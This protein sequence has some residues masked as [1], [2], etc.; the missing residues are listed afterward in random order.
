MKQVQHP[1]LL[2]LVIGI[3]LCADC[4]RHSQP[5]QNNSPA[6]N[7]TPVAAADQNTNQ[8]E[9]DE[10][11]RREALVEAMA[12]AETGYVE[13]LNR[14]EVPL[15]NYPVEDFNPP[16]DY[17][18][19]YSTD[20][21]YPGYLLCEYPVD[22]AQYFQTN[23]PGWFK[24]ALEQIRKLGPQKFPPI[25]WVAVAI[26]NRAEQKGAST[27]E[28]SYKVGAIFKASDVFNRSCSLSQMIAHAAM[29]RHPFEY[30][31]SQPTPGDRQ[32]WLIVEQHAATNDTTSGQPK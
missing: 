31:T 16:P 28:Q 25:K 15:P 21:H 3:F 32:R 23:E 29:D 27:F 22:E 10:Q 26:H 4:G 14:K 30:D 13:K 12:Y 1:A 6:A 20:D 24:A 5:A 9:E 19:F 7:L 18:N 8:S 11:K 2:V 17:V